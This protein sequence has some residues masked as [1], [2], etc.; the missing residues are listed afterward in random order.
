MMG[1]LVLDITRNRADI[2]C[3]DAEGAVSFLPAQSGSALVHPLEELD[4]RSRTALAS[5][6]A[7]QKGGLLLRGAANR[8]L[9]TAELITE[10]REQGTETRYFGNHPQNENECHNG[11]CVLLV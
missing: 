5:A 2:G 11:A 6:N 9:S 8:E 1:L 4:F 10:N 3:A 7:W